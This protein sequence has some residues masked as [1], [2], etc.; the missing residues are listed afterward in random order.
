M[1]HHP[2]HPRA[3]CTRTR[4][5]LSHLSDM[6]RPTPSPSPSPSPGLLHLG[7]VWYRTSVPAYQ[8]ICMG[9]Q[10]K[11]TDFWYVPG[12]FLVQVTFEPS[13][14]KF[15]LFPRP[16]WV[17]IGD[18]LWVT[19]HAH[20]WSVV[21]IGDILHPMWVWT[22]TPIQH[23][24]VTQRDRRRRATTTTCDDDDV[25]RRATTYGA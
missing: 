12:N 25:R 10:C 17:M 19:P 23:R 4:R 14:C 21:M 5:R 15:A 1:T 20:L 22:P 24:I 13:I 16:S 11:I 18:P 2:N 6:R 9:K 3:R 8:P 7:T